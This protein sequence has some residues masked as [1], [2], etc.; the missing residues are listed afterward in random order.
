MMQKYGDS[1]PTTS[2]TSET[3]LNIS[4][5]AILRDAGVSVLVKV[6]TVAEWALFAWGKDAGERGASLGMDVD[7]V[8]TS[9]RDVREVAKSIRRM[10]WGISLSHR[11]LDSP[12]FC[13]VPNSH[14]NAW[15]SEDDYRN[16]E[17]WVRMA[18][19]QLTCRQRL[20]EA[21]GSSLKDDLEVDADL[22]D[23]DIESTTALLRR[24]GKHL[25]YVY[26]DY[27]LEAAAKELLALQAPLCTGTLNVHPVTQLHRAHIAHE[28]GRVNNYIDGGLTAGEKKGVEAIE[29][30][31]LCRRWLDDNGYIQQ[32]Q[33]QQQQS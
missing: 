25:D 31:D 22:H 11:Q 12:E 26:T 30:D 19:G 24:L 33:H 21:A 32:Q 7:A 13:V 14:G 29:K 15:L 9:H 10:R 18:R 6:H 8:Y 3:K 28:N 4:N 5:A 20:L 27:Q 23:L 1:Y 16:P 2:G 17:V